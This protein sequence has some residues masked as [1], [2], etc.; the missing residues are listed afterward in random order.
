ML[1]VFSGNLQEKRTR[2][3]LKNIQNLFMYVEMC[4]EMYI[5]IEKIIQKKFF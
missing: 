2:E 5:C 3:N 1:Y 4:I